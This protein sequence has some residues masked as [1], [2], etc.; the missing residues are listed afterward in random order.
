[1]YCCI[2]LCLI[3]FYASGLLP[4]LISWLI[5]C[6]HQ[7]AEN[8]ELQEKIIHLEQRLASVSVDKLSHSSEQRTSDEYADELG[9]KMQ[10]Q[11]IAA[12]SLLQL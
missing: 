8:K 10:S 1:M 7:C 4:I 6:Y 9:K 5:F 11:V 2:P 12:T 3:H